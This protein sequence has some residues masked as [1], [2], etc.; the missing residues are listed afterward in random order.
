MARRFSLEQVAQKYR[1]RPF[2]T[3]VV[4][5]SG[6]T[7]VSPGRGPACTAPDSSEAG[8]APQKAQTTGSEDDTGP[9]YARP[10]TRVLARHT[11]PA[12]NAAH[13]RPRQPDTATGVGVGAVT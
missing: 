6:G 11:D 8:V 10:P 2:S 3:A 5:V 12:H 1:V 4:Q 9:A 7:A 13:D